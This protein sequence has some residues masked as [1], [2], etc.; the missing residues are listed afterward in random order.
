MLAVL[1]HRTFNQPEWWLHSNL[2]PHSSIIVLHLQELNTKKNKNN[3]CLKLLSNYQSNLKLHHSSWPCLVLLQFDYPATWYHF[4]EHF[5]S[6]HKNPPIRYATPTRFPWPGVPKWSSIQPWLGP[7]SWSECQLHVL[8][9]GKLS[10][11]LILLLVIETISNP[12]TAG[13]ECGC[14]LC[15]SSTD[16]AF[17]TMSLYILPPCDQ[18]LNCSSLYLMTL[19][20]TLTANSLISHS[21]LFVY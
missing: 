1:P 17:L 8:S 20:I 10:Y 16:K 9:I 6:S 14:E 11:I 12:W 19:H 7:Q 4:P 13:C 3:I 15:V 18:I 5:T 2:A 21:A